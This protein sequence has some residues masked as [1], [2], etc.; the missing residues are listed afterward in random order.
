MNYLCKWG[1]LRR[2]YQLCNRKFIVKA[3]YSGKKSLWR[4]FENSIVTII[5]QGA[6]VALILYDS[7]PFWIKVILFIFIG[8]SIYSYTEKRIE[9]EYKDIYNDNNL[10]LHPF[11]K[12]TYYLSYFLFCKNIK[13][14][15]IKCDDIEN[16]LE[17]EKVENE[18]HNISH[19]VKSPIILMCI[20]VISTILVEYLKQNNYIKSQFVFS[21]FFMFFMLISIVLFVGGYL[22]DER[23][24]HLDVCKF[25]RWYSLDMRGTQSKEIKK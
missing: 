2:I 24:M 5:A 20:P 7:F 14:S 4:N 22:G 23:K 6:I 16:L 3:T 21:I 11:F 8:I 13:F 9:S 19:I 17:W 10:K 1:E 25:L 12:R 15:C 18:K